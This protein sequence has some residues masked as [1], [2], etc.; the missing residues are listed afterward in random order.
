M[1]IFALDGNAI[2][3]DSIFLQLFP[4]RKANRIEVRLIKLKPDTDT[5]KV[6]SQLVYG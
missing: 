5:E 1:L 3:I 2:A 6:R 4:E